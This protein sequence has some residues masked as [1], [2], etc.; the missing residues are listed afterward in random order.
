MTQGHLKI[1]IPTRLR[2]V[3]PIYKELVIETVAEMEIGW[4]KLL[5]SGPSLAA[6]SFS[7]YN[8]AC[9][10]TG[11]YQTVT[12]G[13]ISCESFILMGLFLD[14]VATGSHLCSKVLA[15]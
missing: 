15:D 6:K 12:I 14:C 11:R 7:S 8:L 13:M 2:M 10:Q 1:T 9:T 5:F 3:E 4:R